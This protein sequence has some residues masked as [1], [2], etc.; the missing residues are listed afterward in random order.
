[1]VE[2]ATG[3]PVWGQQLGNV[4]TSS[5][6][7]VTMPTYTL[8]VT[9]AG[10][11]SASTGGTGAGCG[12]AE[13]SAFS[14][15]ASAGNRLLGALCRS[16]SLDPAAPQPCSRALDG[17]PGSAFGTRSDAAS[18][19]AGLPGDALPWLVAS[20]SG[21]DPVA[22]ITLLPRQDGAA[23]ALASGALLELLVASTGQVYFSARVGALSNASLLTF[24]PP[25][26]YAVRLSKPAARGPYT[27]PGSG[28]DTNQWVLNLAE[29]TG[30]CGAFV[31]STGRCGAGGWETRSRSW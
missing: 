15:N 28:S 8:R 14:F 17:A 20:L 23:Y 27:N 6:F 7:S 1:V 4:T 11:R 10:A 25:L 5:A 13:L 3:L 12:F 24:R 21:S 31:P 30:F 19:A 2:A 22:S 26:P 18:A 29:L 9:C 16:S